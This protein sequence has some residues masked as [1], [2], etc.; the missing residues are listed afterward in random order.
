M[1]LES[2]D[3]PVILLLVFLEGILSI[4]NALVLAILARR[5]PE[6]Q[7]K[8]ALMWGIIGAVVL[9]L[10]ALTIIN[11]LIKWVWVK[12]VGGGY[13]VWLAIN[14]WLKKDRKKE[15]TKAGG[16]SAFWKTVTAMIFM[17]LAFA[18]DS[19][20]AAFG[21]SKKFVVIFLGGVIGLIL[22]RFAAIVFM[23]LLKKFPKFEEVAYLLIFLIGAKL[24]LEG[25]EWSWLDFHN[26]SQPPFW[27]FWG[28]MVL[29]ILYGFLPGKVAEVR[30]D[31]EMLKE[32]EEVIEEI[33]RGGEH[34][35]KD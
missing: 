28:A 3:I 9:R 33:E 16:K 12:F 30:K 5:L 34:E 6:K 8:P 25:F 17:D 10:G 23:K 20:L 35:G 24:V 19:I 2:S 4:D 15:E 1:G 7:Q 26:K 18:M 14:H 11:Y 27:V 13:L 22:I 21:V 29:S 32:E 31:I